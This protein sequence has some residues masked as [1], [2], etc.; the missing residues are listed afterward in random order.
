MTQETQKQKFAGRTALITGASRGIGYEMALALAAQGAHILGLARTVGGLEELDDK[1][2]SAGGTCSLIPVD[3]TDAE[4][5][6][7]LGPA[8]AARFPSIDIV[9]ANAGDL[10]ELAPVSDINPKIWQRVIDTNLTANWRLIR[11]LDPFLRQADAGRVLFV[12]SRI[13]GEIARPFWGAY[14]VS[15]A[16]LE[17][18]AQTY[19]EEMQSSN[20]RV[21]IIDPGA[22]QTAM[23]ARAMPG[24]DPDTLPHPRELAELV[25]YA[26]S[27]EYNGIAER[28]KFREWQQSTTKA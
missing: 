5:I 26:A 9:L 7:K 18:L 12:S 15:K 11:I 13:G 21:A 8:L 16:G 10:G 19:A 4:A 20:I 25:L 24:E 17:M 27:T 14:G 23:R 2:K 28:L 22:M 1:I 3:I 6:E